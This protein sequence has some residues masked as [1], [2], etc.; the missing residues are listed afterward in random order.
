MWERLLA[1]LLAVLGLP[2]DCA[3]DVGEGARPRMVLL[4]APWCQWCR[5][6]EHE[7]LPHPE[8]RSLL[9]ARFHVEHVDV[10]AQPSW[11]DRPG[12][13]GLPSLLF[14][15]A[16]GRHVLTRSGYLP[17]P[18]T[19][20]LLEAV[21]AKVARGALEPYPDGGEGRT[22]PEE[23]LD[24]EDAAAAL[25]RLEREVF[26]EVSQADGGFGTPARHPHP[27]LLLALQRW[28]TPPTADSPRGRGRGRPAPQRTE[29][30]IS[31][32]ITSALRG[33]SPRLDGEPLPGMEEAYP[34]E[35]L[36]RLS[37][38]GPAAGEAWRDGIERLPDLDPWQG[39]QDPVD[40]G[41]FRYCAGPGWY[42]PHF[43][44]R[45]ADNLSWAL[46]LEARGRDD[47]A[48]RI[49]RFVEDTFADGDLLDTSQRSNPF[50][51]RLRADERAGV[52][53]PTVFPLKTLLVQARAAR[54]IPERCDALDR[55]PADR[56]PPGTL[57]EEAPREA[58]VDEVGELLL[59]LD[60]CGEDARARTLAGVVVERWSREPLPPSGLRPQRLNRLAAGLCEVGSE[61]CGRAV[62]AVADLPLD[63]DQAPPFAALAGEASP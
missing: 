11:M 6:F 34:A 53:P 7:V 27:D 26:F 62:A 29:G 45:A 15:D 16:Q 8:V 23:A 42:H 56:W 58:T 10:D 36:V 2:S 47:E 46:L 60:A 40:G 19:T 35:T 9:D 1:A 54:A 55:V 14:F 31:N 41:V 48:G 13:K 57:G 50:Y 3:P 4:T 25:E 38:Q 61:A 49:L 51:F 63:L 20:I 32:T 18:E 28:I 22:L 30:W 12:V 39:L 37:E 17:V 5:V 52:A 43:E 21:S 59:A 44:R 24:R 33:R